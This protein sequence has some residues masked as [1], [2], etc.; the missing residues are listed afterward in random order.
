M[1][2]NSK[3]QTW[4]VD[5]ILGVALFL[6]LIVVVYML[7]ATSPL[8]DLE[9]R[10]DAD[11]IYSKFDR[12]KSV[13]PEIPSI[14]LSNTLD[15]ES[16]QEL[17]DKDYEELRSKLNIKGDFCIVVTY[18]HG[19]IHNLSEDKRSFGKEADGLVLGRE[20]DTKIICGN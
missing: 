11:L 9:L 20:G 19:G 6:I 12:D 16:F 15:N 8:S 2:I 17:L 18:M 7:M 3:G 4:S 1:K 14:F 13:D 10:R 5:I